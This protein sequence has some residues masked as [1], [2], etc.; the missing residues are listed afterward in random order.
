MPK[1]CTRRCAGGSATASSVHL[2]WSGVGREG[3][4]GNA[5][6]NP[7]DLTDSILI[8]SI[9]KVVFRVVHQGPSA[10]HEFAIESLPNSILLRGIR[11]CTLMVNTF[12]GK[13]CLEF[14]VHVLPPIIAAQ[15]VD[16][17][18]YLVLGTSD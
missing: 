15:L 12:L 18:P 13:I 8:E 4:S 1:P 11:V 7:V 5:I 10:I 16:L 14:G 17:L 3:A 6:A 9:W 2:R